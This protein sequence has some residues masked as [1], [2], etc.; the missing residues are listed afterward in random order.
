M[1]NTKYNYRKMKPEPEKRLSVNG[2]VLGWNFIG[3]TN[4]SDIS[5]F[6]RSYNKIVNKQSYFYINK[7]V[8]LSDI[9]SDLRMTRARFLDILMS[10]LW[11]KIAFKN[12]YNSIPLVTNTVYSI[13]AT[14]H[15][16]FI[17]KRGDTNLTMGYNFQLKT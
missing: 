17:A 6:V 12:A 1:I 8:R 13:D 3:K 2:G 15:M 4:M 10:I 11:S 14:G 9:C 16:A 5:N 7:V